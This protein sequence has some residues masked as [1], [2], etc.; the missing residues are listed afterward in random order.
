MDITDNEVMTEGDV[1]ESGIVNG[2][3]VYPSSFSFYDELRS[4]PRSTFRPVQSPPTN[5]VDT[6]RGRTMHIASNPE[7]LGGG[8]FESVTM[9]HVP[10]FLRYTEND[11]VSEKLHDV[12]SASYGGAAGALLAIHHFNNGIG[13]IVKD[14]GGINERCNI[15]FTTEVI[16]TQSSPIVAVQS[17]TDMIASREKTDIQSPQPCAVMGAAL[18]TVSRSMATVAGVYDILQVSPSSSS[19][20]LDSMLQYPLFSRTHPSDEAKGLLAVEYFESIFGIKN[21]GVLFVN[22]EQGISLQKTIVDSAAKRGMAVRTVSFEADS[23]ASSLRNS[24]VQLKETGFN[25][26]VGVFFPFSYE[27]VMATA[28]DVG[29]AGEGK[30]WLA[31]GHLAE[32]FAAGNKTIVAG[33]KASQGSRGVGVLHDDGEY[34]LPHYDNFANHWRRLG[35][36]QEA[37]EYIN[38]IQPSPPESA[39]SM[40]F[41]RTADYFDLRPSHYSQFSFDAIAGMG[42]AACRAAQASN[43]PDNYFTGKEHHQRFVSHPFDGATGHVTFTANAS[44]SRDG[45]STNYFLSEINEIDRPTRNTSIFS[46]TTRMYYDTKQEI[47]TQFPGASSYVYADGTTTPPS[48]LPPYEEV[49]YGVTA[50]VQVVCFTLA[51]IAIS[52][53][54]AMAAYVYAK[55]AHEIIA[56]SQ[57]PFLYMLCVGTLVMSSAIIPVAIDDSIATPAGC[58]VA[59]MAKIWLAS[60]GFTITFSALFSKTLRINKLLRKARGCQRVTITPGDV[61][62]PFLIL[63]FINVMLLALWTALAPLTFSRRG[64]EYDRFGRQIESVGI[65]HSEGWLPYGI[66]LLVTNFAALI[67]CII[68]AY[69]ARNIQSEFS[70][71]KYIGVAVVSIFQALLFGIPLFFL[72][73]SNPSS[74]SFIL[75]AVVFVCSMAVLLLIFVPKIIL[76]RTGVA[77]RRSP[78]NSDQE[79]SFVHRRQSK[80]PV[81]GVPT[82]SG[83]AASG[84]TVRRSSSLPMSAV[85]LASHIATRDDRFDSEERCELLQQDLEKANRRISD[86]Q[87]QIDELKG[88]AEV[89]QTDAWIDEA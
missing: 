75:A 24:L 25:Y 6:A 7:M 62:K 50:P 8:P 52:M 45:K 83:V 54:I 34:G 41:T 44:F 53:S 68:E 85:V 74:Q 51:A 42:I 82:V 43:R 11:E 73:Q 15:R 80:I 31:T 87:L 77:T 19:M 65:C 3:G 48:E 81:G 64:L 23:D 60:I 28:A 47:W 1:S 5:G 63:L 29:V 38:S 88:P 67:L 32:T 55:R 56:A 46:G 9:C 72:T 13:S 89:H 4:S 61:I 70:E 84:T 57:P 78:N 18:Y 30:Y 27:T 66:S 37:L 49:E 59:C 76:V 20:S 79:E 21:F 35:R 36:N 22:S 16:D 86:L 14:L 71:S 39:P 40:N 58:S 10:I 17:L 33:S 69:R 26:F 12:S 2:A